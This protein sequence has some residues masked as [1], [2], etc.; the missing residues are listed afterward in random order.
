MGQPYSIPDSRP[1]RGQQFSPAIKQSREEMVPSGLKDKV[2][3][4]L[5]M[6]TVTFENP[7][8]YIQFTPD[9]SFNLRVPPQVRAGQLDSVYLV[10]RSEEDESPKT[11]LCY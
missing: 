5:L 9:L 8:C 10:T 1:D 11:Q 7:S 4:R 3:R 2:G 6:G